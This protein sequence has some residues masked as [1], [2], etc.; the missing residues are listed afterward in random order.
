MQGL[1]PK[2]THTRICMC[3]LK[4]DVGVFAFNDFAQLAACRLSGHP[5]QVSAR[6]S[7]LCRAV[8]LWH[9]DRGKKK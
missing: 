8:R 2:D 5:R 4:G 6:D 1:A 7:F 3:L 9:E